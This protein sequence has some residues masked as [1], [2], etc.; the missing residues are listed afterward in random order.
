MKLLIVEDEVRL[1]DRI[2]EG[3]AWEQN[4]I[5]LIGA[6]GTGEEA[7]RLVEKIG[8]D[9]VLTDIQMPVMSGLE[10][11]R[12]LQ[13]QHRHIKLIVLTG[14]DEFDYA[15]ESIEYGVSKYVLKPAS[16]DSILVTVLDAASKR[17][18]ELEEQHQYDLLKERWKTH[19]PR[20]HEAFYRNWLTGSYASWELDKRGEEVHLKLPEQLYI[21]VILDIDP[22]NE[23]DTRF[24]P[25]DRSL[26]LFSLNTIAKER[27]V[28][29]SAFIFQDTNGTTVV[30]FM[31]SVD[32]NRM[33]FYQCVNHAVTDV[34]TM[35]KDSLKITA[36]AGIGPIVAAKE[37]LPDAYLKAKMALQTRIVYGHNIAITFHED[38]A[39]ANKWTSLADMEKQLE[40][41][42]ELGDEHQ[43]KEVAGQ[44]IRSAFAT[45]SVNEVREFL[46]HISGMLSR[47]IHARQWL[48]A[49]VTGD[50]YPFFES[51]N[52][53]L[54]RE[55]I[56]EW[57]IRVI[58]RIC[59]FVNESRKSS[60]KQSVTD[61]L[62]F[63]DARLHED[64]SL[65]QISEI[66]FMNSS[67][68]SR[69]FKEEM[70]MSFTDYVLERKMER[71][72]ALLVQGA[73][74]YEAAEQ[75]GFRHVN[76]FS[77]A[78][79]KYWGMKPGDLNK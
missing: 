9:I 43:A 73:K 48:L 44:M 1:R 28:E 64:I 72:K 42:F 74:V 70:G 46:I 5:E 78:F 11:A 17:R 57:I 35:T 53:L 71:A 54:T 8:A 58:G 51:L 32:D 41:S 16:N 59:L 10:L 34:L 36:S 62:K 50:D 27:L 79:Q 15:R 7:L 13:Q 45:G 47:F 19:L 20:L 21:P 30:L 76:Y 38:Q 3:I 18:M 4:G 75:V 2:A 31:G 6:V 23:D 77:K 39:A 55:Q 22:L 69:L 24:L 49:E 25:S 66:L 14:H 68:L 67:Y 63:I 52:Q 33:D 37:L 12:V 56:Q 26:L 61:I 60:T 40:T 29:A 65:Y